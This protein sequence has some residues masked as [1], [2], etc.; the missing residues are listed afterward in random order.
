VEELLE[1]LRER[2][3]EARRGTD[4]LVEQVIREYVLEL[5]CFEQYVITQCYGLRGE[6]A[7]A[8]AVASDLALTLR[9]LWQ[10][11]SAAFERLGYRLLTDYVRP[12]RRLVRDGQAQAA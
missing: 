11:E 2:G 3:L 7:S 9:D 1:A 8:N 5:P 4:V 10:I 6:P 12:S